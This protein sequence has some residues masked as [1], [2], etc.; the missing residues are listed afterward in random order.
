MKIAS[1]SF[2]FNIKG[3]KR[4]VSFLNITT[5]AILLAPVNLKFI[6]KCLWIVYLQSRLSVYLV[7]FSVRLMTQYHEDGLKMDPNQF[8]RHALASLNT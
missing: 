4:C 8:K 5:S 2:L 6:R 1:E 3:K 7:F